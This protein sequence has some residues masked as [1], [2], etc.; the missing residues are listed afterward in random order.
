M[1]YIPPHKRHSESSAAA[2]VSFDPPVSEESKLAR[3]KINRQEVL[4]KGK[5]SGTGRFA[6]KALRITNCGLKIALTTWNCL[7]W[8]RTIDLRPCFFHTGMAH[9]RCW[10]KSENGGK[11]YVEE[12]K[13]SLVARVGRIL[14]HGL[15]LWSFDFKDLFAVCVN[16][17]LVRFAR[18]V[19]LKLHGNCIPNTGMKTCENDPVFQ[20][21]GGQHKVDLGSLSV[22]LVL[23]SELQLHMQKPNGSHC[24]RKLLNEQCQANFEREI[25]AALR[26][27]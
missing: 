21:L 6:I 19:T 9:R 22:F 18:E 14:F 8:R 5:D 13:P 12:V 10:V 23:V 27:A 26:I 25:A 3:R 1:A 2:G 20:M 7:V 16:F 11:M 24:T 17:M 15:V 4:G